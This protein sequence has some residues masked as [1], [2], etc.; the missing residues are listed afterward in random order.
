MRHRSVVC[1]VLLVVV[2]SACAAPAAP[3]RQPPDP[4]VRPTVGLSPT[5]T[6]RATQTPAVEEPDRSAV[7]PPSVGRVE[8]TFTPYAGESRTSVD[9][10]PMGEP[11]NY[12]NVTFGY[13]LQYPES[14]YTG[15][16]N[17][18]LL[19]S[20]SNL[21]PGTH[22]RASMR[23]EGCLIQVH[24]SINVYGSILQELVGQGSTAFPNARTVELDGEPGLL[25]PP[26][27]E[28]D[29]VLSETV[30][31]SHDD[32]MFV[33]TL[34]YA[35]DSGETCRPAWE[36]ML[37]TWKWVAPQF[38][39]Y[40][41]AEYVYAISYPRHWYRFNA[42][43][44]GIYISSQDPT[45]SPDLLGLMRE[46][47]VVQTDVFDNPQNLTL[48]E[49]LA[50]TDWDMDLTNDIPLYGQLVGVRVVGEGPAPGIQRMSG[51]FQG[52]LGEVYGVM[53][54]YPADREWEFRPIANA[55]IYSF[56]F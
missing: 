5:S 38:A 11:G 41:N 8:P 13:W 55:I 51:Y 39:V 48:K 37:S 28:G 23:S 40:R 19:A 29:A 45:G 16:G 4:T 24:A 3:S 10:L 33:L 54:H 15:F 34:D 49:W 36:N 31:I 17:R 53:C 35:V 7:V 56:S 42:G 1:T 9:G 6:P 12:V 32:V 46:A 22:N 14:W 26:D 21:S 44:R 20:F 27:N 47:M 25:I 50:Q 43:E 2:L 18:P 52:P 30:V